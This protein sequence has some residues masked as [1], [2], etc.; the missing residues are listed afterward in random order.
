MKIFHLFFI[1]ILLLIVFFAGQKTIKSLRQDAIQ[2]ASN[3]LELT[4][5]I[6][7]T[8]LKSEVKTIYSEIRFWAESQP[9]RQGMSL[10][11]AGWDELSI[12]PKATARKL[13]ITDNPLFPNY[14][15]NYY[16]AEDG[17][18]YSDQHEK[19]HKL[20]RGLTKSRGYY[21]VFLIAN[22]GDIIY[23]VYKENDYASNLLT[24]NYKETSLAEGFREVQENTN[25]NHVALYDFIPYAA[26]NN[27]AS[28][29]IL[30]SIVD[31]K[32]KTQGV[33]AFQLPTETLD[34]ILKSIVTEDKKIIIMAVGSNHLL[35]N[36]I[37]GKTIDAKQQSS[38]ITKALE[39]KTGLDTLENTKGISYLTAYAPFDFS[40]NILGNTN[41][42]RWAVIVKQDINEVLSPVNK[43]IKKWINLLLGLTLL[44]LLLSW[45]FTR[46]KEDLAITEEEEEVT[47]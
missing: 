26:S 32:N 15:A 35:R 17:S 44:S 30:S 41:K 5:D 42:N 12:D 9:I 34:K 18:L 45:L 33:L 40:L 46:G 43:R 29:F 1:I 7:I 14:T 13:Y 39:G 21:D 47:H 3:N 27:V 28:S 25:L 10:I 22:N 24:G 4:R 31:N 38:V 20:I 8:Q 6:R 11:L 16:N 23:T 19:M 36:R 2:Q 37:E